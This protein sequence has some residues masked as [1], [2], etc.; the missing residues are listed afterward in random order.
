MFKFN[1]KAASTP[2]YSWENVYTI[3]PFYGTDRTTGK[4]IVPYADFPKGD[5]FSTVP[6]TRFFYKV[7]ETGE[8]LTRKLNT[9]DTVDRV[10][11]RDGQQVKIDCG[12][13]KLR[14]EICAAACTEMDIFAALEWLAK[15]GRKVKARIQQ[16]P[17]N[18]EDG[19]QRRDENGNLMWWYQMRLVP[20]ETGLKEEAP[21]VEMAAEAEAKRARK[22]KRGYAGNTG[23]C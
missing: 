11:I 18:D 9:Y 4:A 15:D 6:Y 13:K 5:K 22:G 10:E 12:Q 14:K 3:V 20:P 7:V 1:F 17:V 21:A 19:E 23:D 2:L 8:V 16:K